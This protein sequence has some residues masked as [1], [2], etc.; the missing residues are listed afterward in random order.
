MREAEAEYR[1]LNDQPYASV[2]DP[3]G[4]SK[5]VLKLRQLIIDSRD[6]TP[7]TI[8]IEASWGRG[9]SSLMLQLQAALRGRE[10]RSSWIRVK[11]PL[12]RPPADRE[13]HW[14]D[15]VPGLDEVRVAN[16]NAWTAEA[17]DVLE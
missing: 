13:E 4:F 3:F 10:K 8:G 7:C 5:L 12:R 1:V 9:K 11:S 2:D 14:L 16:F 6:S 15:T 17:D